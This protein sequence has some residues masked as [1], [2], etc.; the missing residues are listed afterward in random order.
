MEEL[1]EFILEN[2]PKTEYYKKNHHKIE[3]GLGREYF[4]E[5]ERW[6]LWEWV[7]VINRQA[8]IYFRKS[9]NPSRD[10]SSRASE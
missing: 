9:S 7:K 2:I 4:S 10:T 8:G 6:A 3:G 1:I 5:L